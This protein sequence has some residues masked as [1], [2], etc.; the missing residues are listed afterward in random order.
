[1]KPK[2]EDIKRITETD[3]E[4]NIRRSHKGKVEENVKIKIVIPLL[5]LLGY[6]TL[7]DLD[8]EYNVRTKRADIAIELDGKAR[9]SIECKDLSEN[10]DSHLT[11]AFTYACLKGFLL[12]LLTN[13]KEI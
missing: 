8:F 1:M 13:G 6:D 4:K 7:K 2:V 11:Q 3:I 10:L 12:L 5:N 9:V